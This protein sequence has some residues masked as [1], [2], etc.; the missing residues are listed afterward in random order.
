MSFVGDY[1]EGVQIIRERILSQT[2]RLVRYTRFEGMRTV[3]AVRNIIKMVVD[4]ARRMD[5]VPSW[6]EDDFDI[7]PRYIHEQHTIDILFTPKTPLGRDVARA[8][9]EARDRLDLLCLED[10]WDRT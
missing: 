6:I 8:I 2:A 10:E 9:D 7:V 4:E 1:A 3:F 5:L